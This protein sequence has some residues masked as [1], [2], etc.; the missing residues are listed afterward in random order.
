M[1]KLIEGIR[2]NKDGNYEFDYSFNLPT[3]IIDIT[4]QRIYKDIFQN[5]IYWFGYQFNNSCS[6]KDRTEFINYI[7]GLTEP[8]ITEEELRK[9]IQ[10]PLVELNKYINQYKIDCFISPRSNRS[11]LVQIM[12]EEIGKSTSRDMN[13]CSF[14]LVKELPS[15]ITFDWEL[16]ENDHVGNEQAYKDIKEY[17]DNILIPK[18]NSLN[19]F[20]LAKNVK[21]KYRKYIQNYL[22]FSSDKDKQTF[23]K[24]QG[25]NI[26]IVD[27]INTSGS[28]L[29]EILRII[30]SINTMCNIYIYTLIGR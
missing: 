25:Q 17:V 19:Y 21:P 20:S 7:K 6:R 3:D 11:N 2:K 16:F 30:N 26:L 5:N 14:E 28:T 15:N 1:G 18:I 9:F 24:L 10:Y 27:D 29:Q 4:S 13:K 22:K 8:K 23:E 12:V